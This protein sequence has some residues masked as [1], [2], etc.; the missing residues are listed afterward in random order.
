VLSL[1]PGSP[2]ID[3]P[4]WTVG[5]AAPSHIEPHVPRVTCTPSILCA[6]PCIVVV[7]TGAS[8]AAMVARALRGD[9]D[10]HA[11][12]AQLARR[13]GATW[14]LDAEAASALP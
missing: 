13:P 9:R 14:I 5:V 11:L 7:A 1:F 4:G 8:K 2:A 10:V 6:T 3:A 12:P